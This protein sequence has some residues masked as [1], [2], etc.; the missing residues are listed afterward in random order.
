[1]SLEEFTNK[2]S[3]HGHVNGAQPT[4]PYHRH[5]WESKQLYSVIDCLH[6]NCSILD[7]GCGGRGTLQHTLF[8]HFPNAKY[9]GLDVEFE[10]G[11]NIG[12]LET[13]N[14]TEDNVYFGDISELPQVLPK[15][16]CMV[17]GSV[18]T[19][20]SLKAMEETLNETLPYYD[21]GFQL[22]F[23]A[24]MGNR[25]V[26]SGEGVYGPETYQYTILDFAWF[27]DYCCNNNLTFISHPYRYKLGGIRPN[28]EKYGF[29]IQEF[30]H[31]HFI[32]IKK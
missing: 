25:F 31:Q 5:L 9:Y 10:S 29:E 2:I 16:D 32:T 18:F 11:C 1:M 28:G 4:D 21:K 30:H 6:D 22:G 8:N 19:H 27:R 20:L 14:K 12:Y 24:F 17:M 15:V 7:F 23:T 3:P 26:F 13:K